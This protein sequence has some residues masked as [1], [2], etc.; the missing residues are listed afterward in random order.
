MEINMKIFLSA[1]L[2]LLIT[3][4]SPGASNKT[5]SRKH[6]NLDKLTTEISDLQ[7]KEEATTKNSKDSLHLK[8]RIAELDAKFAQKRIEGSLAHVNHD[9]IAVKGALSGHTK[10]YNFN[11]KYKVMVI[12]VQFTDAKMH[13]ASFF[14]K[15]ENGVVP[16]DDYI[17]GKGKNSLA[18]YYKHSSGGKLAVSGTVLPI[19]TVDKSL[20]FYGEAINGG[21]DRN[22]RKLV[23]DALLKV[24][25]MN[26][27]P[28][29]WAQFDRWDLN[30]YDSDKVFSE[31][32]GFI[33]AVVLIYAGKSQASCQRSFDA[34]GLKPASADV[35]AGPRQ[36][37]S[38]ECF[39]RIWP[40]R[41]NI[42]ISS[43][44][45]NHSKLGPMIEGIQRS[46]F[47]GLKIDEDLFA[48]DYNMQS[49]FSDI[50]TFIHEFGHSLTLP[51]IYSKGKGNS[52]GQ[53]EIMSS[54]SNL[55]AQ[56]MSSFSKISLGWLKPKVIKQGEKSSAYLG[57]YNFISENQRENTN[58]FLG[59]M[60]STQSIDGKVQ[61]VSIISQTPE[62]GEDVYRSVAIITDPSK[63]KITVVEDQ[64]GINNKAAY[65][66]RFDGDSKSILVKVLVPKTGDA[67]LSF[68]T[69]YH[70]ETETNFTAKEADIKIVVDYDLG[71]I[72]I[73]GETKEELRIISGDDN[74]DTLNESAPGCDIASLLKTRAKFVASELSETESKAF[75]TAAAL[76]QKPTWVKKSYDLSSHRGSEVE[77]EINLT[78]DGGYT[79]FGIIV[80]NIKLGKTL[81][82]FEDGKYLGDFKE[83]QGGIETIQFQQF[84]L[85]EYRT[86]GEEYTDQGLEVSYNMDN[87]I[88]DSQS[89]FVNDGEN[90]QDR[91][92]L[93]ELNYQPG[94]VVWYFNSKY[95]RSKNNPS[96]D[97]GKGYYLVLNGNTG[98]MEIPG[99][100]FDGLLNTEGFYDPESIAHKEIVEE[101]QR[102]FTCFG[103]REYYF[104]QNAQQ[105][106]C[107][108][109]NFVDHLSSIEINGKDLMYRRERFNVLLPKNRYTNY[110]VGKPFRNSVAQRTSLAAFRASD[111]GSVKPFKIYKELDGKMILDEALT[112]AQKAYPA[113]TGFSD[114]D[115]ALHANARFHGDTA[116]VEPAGL[117][118]K[119]I[120]PSNRI[121]G[122]YS[123]NAHQDA[124]DNYFRRPRA[125]ILIN[126]N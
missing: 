99:G 43:N 23:V 89:V 61:N 55:Q 19:V 95:D 17:F 106:K 124:N 58:T 66:G 27:N 118:F 32:D 6:K 114:K 29:W 100:I 85:M 59:P 68:D 11:G 77:L 53:W 115:S 75:F 79:E 110:G 65:S 21:N 22:A 76:C 93:L 52:T 44:D 126:W 39:N 5:I 90:L 70:I 40:H 51:D 117:S 69:I 38:V 63:E 83:L 105:E 10:I 56:E 41:W 94:V 104:Y 73:N 14:S 42:S 2:A 57:A 125:K 86:P 111:T 113:V 1:T 50:S 87:N 47:G 16:A 119:V 72:L 107:D 109:I 101:Q 26:K 54:N 48:L 12:P 25:A 33:D 112:S 80:D 88:S 3:S 82:D 7:S 84:Y 96:A 60:E 108:D 13:D 102:L 28:E 81:I 46:T 78:T 98:E 34:E 64:F 120:S 20:A 30:D 18:Q 67:T 49:E 122:L 121:N 103:W 45:P 92:R 8:N 9:N 71:K 35:P 62:F 31:P 91:F 24:K 74:F 116:V 15:D 4:C 97:K 36:A 123:K 37:A